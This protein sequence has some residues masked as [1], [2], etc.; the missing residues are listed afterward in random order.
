ME[1]TRI[2]ALD[3]FEAHVIPAIEGHWLRDSLAVDFLEQHLPWTVSGDEPL[4]CGPA[5]FGA[6]FGSVQAENLRISR[7][8]M[9]RK[10]MESA[11]RG[12]GASFSRRQNH[13]PT[14][15]LCLIQWQGPW[16]DRVFR[17]SNLQFTH[18]VCVAHGYVF[19]VN[20]SGWLPKSIWEEV[21][22]H[23]L[24]HHHRSAGWEPLTGYEV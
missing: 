14:R 1:S 11:I 20:W 23:D 16:L 4:A 2:S 3:R 6:L 12:I 24:L 10:E 5:A 21:V 9:N 8:Q 19:D 17:G 18:W 13:W 22:V 15:G 7:P